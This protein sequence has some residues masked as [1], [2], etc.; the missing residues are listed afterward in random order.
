MEELA[1]DCVVEFALAVGEEETVADPEAGCDF[2][3]ELMYLFKCLLKSLLFIP[4]F[5]DL[6]LTEPQQISPLLC[7]Q[8]HL[9]KQVVPNNL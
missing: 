2:F 7:H 4:I 9:R 6:L 1:S 8:S 5:L 3:L